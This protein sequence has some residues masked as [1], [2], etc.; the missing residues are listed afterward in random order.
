MNRSCRNRQKGQ[1]VM[2]DDCFEL[3][4]DDLLG[5]LIRFEKMRAF[6]ASP[7][8]RV[9]LFCE[10]EDEFRSM[11]KAE[12]EGDFSFQDAAIDTPLGTNY[13]AEVIRHVNFSKTVNADVV[14][15]FL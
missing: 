10:K 5:F 1:E 2:D 13:A 3:D 11:L 7:I 12:L 15:L 8:T 6:V 4:A 14:F 9:D